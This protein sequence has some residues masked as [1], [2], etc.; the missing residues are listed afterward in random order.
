MLTPTQHK[1]LAFIQSFTKRHQYSP[2]LREIAEEL[3]L[4]PTS[5]S[6]ISR[7]MQKLEKLG[8]LER[9]TGRYRTIHLKKIKPNFA[10]HLAIPFLGKIAAGS[11]IEAIEQQEEID[12]TDLFVTQHKTHEL[13]ALQVKGDSMVEEGILDGDTIICEKAS[14]AYHGA[15]VIALI[16]NYEATLKRIHFIHEGDKKMIKLIPANPHLKPQIYSSSRITIQGIYKG[17]L[18]LPPKV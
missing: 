7:Y 4:S 17:L 8:Y 16:D 11:P 3:N 12:I 5:K 2:S 9:P 13:F 14:T 10:Q 1:M 18:R 6:L 15:I